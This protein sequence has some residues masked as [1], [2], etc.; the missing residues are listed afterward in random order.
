MAV[1]SD[2]RWLCAV[3]RLVRGYLEA[4]GVDAPCAEDVVL[5]VDEACA[6]SIRHSYGGQDD[7]LLELELH[8]DEDAIVIELRDHGQTA[9]AERVARKAASATG[10]LRPGGLGVPLM[11]AVFDKVEFIPETPQGNRVVMSLRRAPRRM[12]EA[13]GA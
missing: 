7:G 11:Y 2:A 4:L 5:A 10:V 12:G 8:S 6:N 9:P 13:C 1:R 3:R